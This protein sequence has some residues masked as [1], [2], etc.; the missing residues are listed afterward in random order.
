MTLIFSVGDP[1]EQMAAVLDGLNRAKDPNQP[2]GDGYFAYALYGLIGL[3]V[4]RQAGRTPPS[5]NLDQFRQA[6][7]QELV[8]Q[9][10][11]FRA[12]NWVT[13]DAAL[14][15][16][17]DGWY[18]ASLGRSV[19]QI[20]LDNFKGTEVEK[21]ID[22]DEIH[23]IDELLRAAAPEASPLQGAE[24]PPG[25]PAHHWWWRL[26][27]GPPRELNHDAYY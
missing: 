21:L 10:S 23:E 14:N 9:A 24:I 18:R 17:N 26:P 3:E 8:K 15:A 20:L 27:S 22:P 19:L 11:A 7:V 5:D 16:R 25:M 13:Y 6:V 12:F 4:S 1:T 2:L